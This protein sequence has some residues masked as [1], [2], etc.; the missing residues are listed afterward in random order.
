MM[1]QLVL[2]PF[3]RTTPKKGSVDDTGICL[4]IGLNG[5]SDPVFLRGTRAKN[6]N[7]RPGIASA[8]KKSVFW[9]RSRPKSPN[10]RRFGLDL[11]GS[12][13]YIPPTFAAGSGFPRS[14]RRA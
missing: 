4:A 9:G 10:F 2:Q 6:R 3:L 14:A 7:F 11:Q 12:G 5:D 8:A 13:L 1:R